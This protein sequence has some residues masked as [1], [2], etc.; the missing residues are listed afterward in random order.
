ICAAGSPT[1]S[2]WSSDIAGRV[3]ENLPQPDSVEKD[4]S[5]HAGTLETGTRIEQEG[6]LMRNILWILCLL[7]VALIAPASA[8]R[9]SPYETTAPLAKALQKSNVYVGRTMRGLVD[10]DALRAIA[11][12][13]PSDRPLKIAVVFQLPASGARYGTRDRYTKALHDYLGL[14]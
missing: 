10:E 4:E 1:C 11:D 7:S 12:R 5:A 14:G 9:S 2:R 6:V 13:A 3:K 8:Q